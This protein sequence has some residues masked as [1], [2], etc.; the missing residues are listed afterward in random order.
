MHRIDFIGRDIDRL[1]LY[2]SVQ[3][4]VGMVLRFGRIDIGDCNSSICVHYSKLVYLPSKNQAFICVMATSTKLLIDI[5][6]GFSSPKGFP[7]VI[8]IRTAEISA[9]FFLDCA[10]MVLGTTSKVSGV[11]KHMSIRE[12]TLRKLYG[13]YGRVDISV[14]DKLSYGSRIHLVTFVWKFDLLI[15]IKTG[16]LGRIKDTP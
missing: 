16:A 9:R 12:S 8:C 13:H 4:F 7:V 6:E 2:G 3:E 1:W 10:L 11:L 14:I 5:I 15:A